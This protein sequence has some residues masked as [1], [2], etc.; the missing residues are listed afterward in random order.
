MNKETAT[1]AMI[2]DRLY[3]LAKAV[4]VILERHN[5]PYSMAFGTLLGAVRHQGFIPWDE[6]FDLWLFDDTYDEAI[7]Y[8]RAELP[9]DMFLEDAK[10][11]PN[12]FHSWAHV[13]DVNSL[14]PHSRYQHDDSYEHKGLYIDLYKLTRMKESE[15][16][17][18]LNSENRKYI[19]RRK[20]LGLISDEEY[21]TRMQKLAE[22]EK[23][24]AVYDGDTDEEIY[25]LISPYKC[26]QLRSEERL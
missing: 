6:D 18:F 10:S 14:A 9:E 15:L 4:I 7:E 3:H 1:P 5:I 20:D 26:K 21:N 23:E 2:C 16:W 12:Y 19:M 17:D 24:H 22:N 13:K 25:S 11:E 8:L